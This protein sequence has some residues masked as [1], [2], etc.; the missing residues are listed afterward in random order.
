MAIGVALLRQ[1]A[2]TRLAVGS[3]SVISRGSLPPVMFIMVV[4]IEVVPEYLDEFTQLMTENMHGTRTEPANKRFDFLRVTGVQ[5]SSLCCFLCV[6]ADVVT[7]VCTQHPNVF[8]PRD[9]PHRAR[10]SSVVFFV[11]FFLSALVFR[12]GR[13]GESVHGV[14]WVF[15]VCIFSLFF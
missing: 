14:C 10:A 3:P 2:P 7:R 1:V 4:T 5:R 12:H 13:A 9:D 6:A 8:L 11:L 15:C